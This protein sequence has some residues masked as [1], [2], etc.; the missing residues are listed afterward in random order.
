MYCVILI[1][2]V[3]IMG[4]ACD[5]F[6]VP[7]STEEANRT[8]WSNLGKLEIEKILRTTENKNRA[9]YVVLFLG[10]GMGV[11]TVT[12]ARIFKGQ[13][14]RNDSG[15]ET[16]LSWEKFP[17]VS[18]S[19]TYGL[20]TQTSDSANSAT[21]YLCGVKANIGTLGVDSTV[22][23][24]Q[25]H[26][27]TAA[28][29]DSIMKWAQDSGMWTGIVT[30]STVTDAS[31][32]GAYAHA[33]YREWQH[34]VPEGCNASD[35]AKQLIYDSPGREMRVIM[36]GGRKEFLN[37]TYCDEHN[38]TGARTDGLNLIEIWKQMKNESN[39][40]YVW[41][42]SA[43]QEVNTSSTDYLLG[44]FASD[45]M[46][47]WLERKL[48]NQSTPGLWDMVKVAVQILKKNDK[49][50][51]LLAEGGRI[52]HAHHVNLAQ[53][54][55]QETVEF[56]GVVGGVSQMLPEN[57]TLIVVTADH[58]HTLNIAGHPPRGTN[59]LGFAGKTETENPVNYTVLSYGV[60]PGGYRPLENVTLRNTTDIMFRQRAAFPV[61]LAPH[62]GED[63]AIYAKGP[64][65][66]LFSG[67]QDQ[68][69][70]PYVMAYAAC[71]GQFNGSECH[72]CKQ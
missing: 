52:D 11:S 36:G 54:A 60:G 44:L 57:E 48:Y 3:T 7:N 21:A 65:A 68:T 40:V 20:D 49:G 13:F 64:W 55:L 67:V 26:N 56:E 33:G 24:G 4:V 14:T 34:S 22:K 31:P 10:D 45:Y 29:V 16:V 15:E 72:E 42:K 70:I 2:I 43:L 18:L 62:G 25:C 47:F 1:V 46:P 23:G 50:F 8:Y 37:A 58:S 35:I 12:A 5:P 19:K 17:Y 63:V 6:K 61:K 27:D 30:T 53:L 9:K 66:H 39:A 51:V 38:Q 41:N 59:I 71:I 69:Y 28:Y 32:A